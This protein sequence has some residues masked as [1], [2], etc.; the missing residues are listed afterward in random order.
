MTHLPHQ[1]LPAE[2][3]NISKFPLTTSLQQTTFKNK[4]MPIEHIKNYE[5]KAMM[6]Y[7]KFMKDHLF[8]IDLSH[9]IITINYNKKT[10]MGG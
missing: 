2:T 6:I 10:R 5:V 4:F 3:Q 8:G 9:I 1:L 7:F